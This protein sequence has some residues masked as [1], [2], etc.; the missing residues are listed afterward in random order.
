MT[1]KNKIGF[2]KKCFE[3]QFFLMT[4]WVNLNIKREN[5][6]LHSQQNSRIQ[7]KHQKMI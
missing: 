4:K 7:G 2:N 1:S 6:I 3:E 5:L